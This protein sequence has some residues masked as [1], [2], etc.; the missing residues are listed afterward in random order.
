MWSPILLWPV[1]ICCEVAPSGRPTRMWARWYW[2]PPAIV[3]GQCGVHFGLADV[4]AAL[5]VTL[6]QALHGDLVADR[7]AEIIEADAL[8]GQLLAQSVDVGAVLLGNAVDCVVQLLV[9]DLDAG[10]GGALDLQLHQHEPLEHRYRSSTFC[11]GSWSS[12]NQILALL[13]AIIT[14]FQRKKHNN[15]IN[16]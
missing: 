7:S 16:G 15:I 2:R 5:A 9:A 13:K 1:A 3:G 12:E 11:G 10:V 8:G 14:M 6:A 4:D